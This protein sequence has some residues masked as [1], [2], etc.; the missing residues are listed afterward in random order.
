MIVPAFLL[1]VLPLC[2]FAGRLGLL[3]RPWWR[4][5][6]LTAALL[7]V[8]WNLPYRGVDFSHLKR[9]NL[10]I[11]AATAL[12]LVFREI[13]VPWLADLKRYVRTLTALAAAS[14]VVYLNFFAFHGEATW[15]HYHDVAHYYLGAKYFRELSYSNLYTAMLRAEAELYDNH[16]K[17]IEARDLRSGDLVHIRDLLTASGPVKAAF[18]PERWAGFKADVAYFRDALGPQYGKLF[19]DHGFNPTPVWAL[20]GGGLANLVPAGSGSGI[21]MLTLLDPLLIAAAFAAVAWAF[22]TETMLLAVIYFC[23][24]FGASFGWTG[25]AFLRYVWFFGVVG[26]FAALARGRHAVAGG[27]LALASALRI[28]PAFFLAGLVFKAIADLV[29]TGRVRRDRQRALV[30]FAI[31]GAVLVGAT[32]PAFGLSS[33]TDFQRNLSRHLGTPSP[34]LVGVTGVITYRSSDVMVT[35]AE[36]RHLREERQS[37]YR[38]QLATGFVIAVLLAAALSASLSDLAAAALGVPLLFFGLNLASYYYVFLVV[39]VLVNRGRPRRLA[40]LF[41]AE[42]VSYALMLFEDRESILYV[43]RSLVVFYLLAALA[44]E[45]RLDRNGDGRL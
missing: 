4:R 28:F 11:A 3:R 18:T 42:A 35:A 6:V 34:N 9:L 8:A 44:L 38:I 17:T 41:T 27:L 5:G 20:L 15:V 12:L 1:A 23:L 16:F 29:T 13:G 33:W 36:I 7:L 37:V 30:A 22:G 45:G 39:L 25:G 14:V 26:A 32:L 24:V 19:R 40:I 2:Y 21:F 43:Y 31:T 10:F